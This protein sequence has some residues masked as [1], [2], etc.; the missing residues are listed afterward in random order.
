MKLLIVASYKN[1]Q[2]TPFITEQVEAL[3]AAG[4]EC[5][6]YG[7]VGKGV[8]GYLKNL[9]GLKEKIKQFKPDLIHAHYGLSGLLANLQRSVGVVTTY[10]GCDINQPTLRILS[11]ISIILSKYAIFVSQKQAKK[12]SFLLRKSIILP[13]GIDTNFFVRVDKKEARLAMNIPLDEKMVLFSS[14]FSRKEKNAELAKLATKQV[15]GVVLRELVGYNRQEYLLM[16]NACDAGLLTSI[17][18]GSP[19]FVKELLACQ[20]PLVSTDVGDV[21]EQISGIEG[22]FITSFQANEVTE[23]LVKALTYKE[24]EY[25]A[26]RRIENDNHQVALKLIQI[27]QSIIEK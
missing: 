12:V 25:P 11:A 7:I 18:E 4:V 16:L 9:K 15:E 13:C 10:H 19:L 24:I 21:A 22:C 3:R 17:R 1:K 5:Q 23:S 8:I 2:F 27:Y 20:K 6:Y 26:S 14:A